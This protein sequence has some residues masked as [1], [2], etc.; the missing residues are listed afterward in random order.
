MIK[1]CV[2][3]IANVH[4]LHKDRSDRVSLEYRMGVADFLNAAEQ[5]KK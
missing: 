2:K 4:T 1:N 3:Y 5:D